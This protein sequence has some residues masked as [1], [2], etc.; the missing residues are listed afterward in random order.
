M[1]RP[2]KIQ[3]VYFEGC[4]TA[5]P[6]RQALAEAMHLLDWDCPVEE[7]DTR[8]PTAPVLQRHYPSPTLLVDGT[9]VFGEARA[10]AG[11][12]RIYPPG[13]LETGNLARALQQALDGPGT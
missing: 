5:A 13:A 8:S 12:C 7:I 11:C 10:D 9:D 6:A 2:G 4:P 1:K 3:F